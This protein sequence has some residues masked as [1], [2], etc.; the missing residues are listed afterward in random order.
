MLIK[1]T[2][3][4]QVTF[5]ASVLD[6]LGVGPG[7][8]RASVGGDADYPT[9]PGVRQKVEVILAQKEGDFYI[10]QFNFAF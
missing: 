4:R 7:G 1:I 8:Y 5:P 3:K 9:P 10:Q 6:V 2:S